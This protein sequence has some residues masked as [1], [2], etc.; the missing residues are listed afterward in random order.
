MTKNTIRL[1]GAEIILLDRTRLFLP[2]KAFGN[3]GRN[4]LE[5]L[6]AQVNRGTSQDRPDDG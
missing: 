1:F 4:I 6:D 3:A 2:C 5:A